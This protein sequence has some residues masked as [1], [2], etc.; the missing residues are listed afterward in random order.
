MYRFPFP[1]AD[2]VINVSAKCICV[3]GQDSGVGYNTGSFDNT[4]QI[5]VE[6][7][8]QDLS[9]VNIR[10]MSLPVFIPVTTIDIIV[11]RV[12]PLMIARSMIVL[13]ELLW[14][15]VLYLIPRAVHVA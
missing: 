10:W 11:K 14:L 2:A 12:R 4:S 13:L 3:D 7:P 5:G 6:S 8:F 15:L 9:S 1:L